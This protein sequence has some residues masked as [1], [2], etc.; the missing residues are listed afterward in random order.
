M[1]G[2]IGGHLDN[3]FSRHKGIF[4]S[5]TNSRFRD[6]LDGT[7]NTIAFVEVTGGEEYNFWWIDNG[8]FPTAWGFGGNFNQLSSFHTGGVQV[9]MGDGSVRFISENI[10]AEWINGTLHSL[11]GMND[12][13]VVG[14]F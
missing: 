3:G 1:G 13:N 6:I 7:S 12:S 14:E 8:A 4:G 5:G 2:P 9:L 10:D 11:A